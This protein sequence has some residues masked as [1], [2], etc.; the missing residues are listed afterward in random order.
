MGI[1]GRGGSSSDGGRVGLGLLLLVLA[2]FPKEAI[3]GLVCG[4]GH[5]VLPPIKGK[6][7]NLLPFL[8]LPT[9]GGS[10]FHASSFF[11]RQEPVGETNPS[12]W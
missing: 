1:D 8:A 7:P 12:N 11:L 4:P 5:M 6:F 10:F 9:L 2:M 3:G